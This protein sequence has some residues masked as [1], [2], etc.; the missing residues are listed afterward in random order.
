VLKSRPN[1][2]IYPLCC[3]SILAILASCGPPRVKLP[4]LKPAQAARQAMTTY[5]ADGNGSLSPDELEKCPGLRASLPTMD[6]DADGNLSAGEISER[7]KSQRATGLA[8][9]SVSCMV[10]LRGRPLEGAT[11]RFVP[12]DFLGDGIQTAAGKTGRGGS[13]A[14]AI[15]GE[16]LP[17]IH[18]GLY[19]VEISKLDQAGAETIPARYNTD[20]TLGQEVSQRVPPEGVAMFELS[21]K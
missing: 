17:G 14:L 20:T 13:A 1:R 5:D 19:R 3:A 10:Y 6:T 9:T 12:E 11:V 21:T 16:E 15:P 8:L 7:L 2:L 18:C 4:P